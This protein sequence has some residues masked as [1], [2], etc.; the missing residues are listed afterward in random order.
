LG[1]FGPE[2]LHEELCDSLEKKF[3]GDGKAIC[4][5]MGCCWVRW[6]RDLGLDLGVDTELIELTILLATRATLLAPDGHECSVIDVGLMLL[7]IRAG[8]GRVEEAPELDDEIMEE[9]CRMRLAWVAGSML[10]RVA[11]A[12]VLARLVSEA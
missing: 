11:P 1:E 5:C 3:F 4:G 8:E 2:L 7:L 12:G 6:A 9:D 10:F